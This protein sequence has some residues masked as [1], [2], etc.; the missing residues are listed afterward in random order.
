M[1]KTK[2]TKENVAEFLNS[3]PYAEFKSLVEGYSTSNK[4]N[5]D[6]EMKRLVTL[7]LQSRLE[8]LGINS[9]CP[10]CSSSDVVKNGKRSTGVQKHK[11]RSCNHEFSLFSGTILE[12]TRWHWDIWVKVLNLTLNGYSIEDM[13]NT[14]QKDYGCDGIDPKTV[15]LWRLKLIHAMASFPMPMLTGIIQVDETFIRES[16]KGSRNLV[17]LIKSEERKPRYG[18]LPSKFGT[19]GPEFATVTTAIDNRGYCVCKVSGLG[20][21]T[22]EQFI[23]LFDSH[24]DCPSYICSDGNN[25][26]KEYCEMFGI[27]H[28]IKPSAYDEVLK[29]NG[30]V[31]FAKKADSVE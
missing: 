15:W 16:Q 8:K 24:F 6:K 14:L 28:Y 7:N 13:V 22:T 5:F 31:S 1:T 4:S 10:N 26:Y 19:M 17:S 29:T 11:C 23:D 18:R 3:L 30:Y 12:K 21:L 2:L 9:V 25:T 20:K 27:P